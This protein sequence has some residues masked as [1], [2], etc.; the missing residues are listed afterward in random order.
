[1]AVR[2]LVVLSVTLATLGCSS[3]STP[4]SATTSSTS[5]T[6]APAF[7]QTELVIG[8]GTTLSNGRFATVHYTLWLYD[9]A[10]PEQ[11]GTQMETSVGGSPYRFLVGAGGVI[12]GWDLGVPGMRVGGQRRLIVPP[13]L[14]YGSSGKGQIGPNQSLVFD[15]EL[16]LVE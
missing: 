8:T 9:P 6:P 12:R 3:N 15:I 7:S 11:K 14:A 5:S 1:M 4:S 10:A 16:V 2:T 13:S